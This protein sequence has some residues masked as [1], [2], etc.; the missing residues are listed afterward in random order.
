[1]TPAA[2]VDQLR[3]AAVSDLH[4][5]AAMRGTFAPRWA[6]L[7]GKADLLVLCGDLTSRGA[8]EE[9]RE[10]LA[11]LEAVEVPTVAVLG[12]HDFDQ[13]A[14]AEISS[15]LSA[16]GIIVLDGNSATLRLQSVEV[17]IAG[18]KGFCGGFR[19]ARVRAEGEAVMRDFAIEGAKE[20]SKLASAL[21][22]LRTPIRIVLTHYSP[23][24]G[25]LVG[26][27]RE[28]VPF[29]G[30]YRLE[31]AIDAAKPDAV[32]HGH[33]HRGSL[34]G[35]TQGGVA[36]YNVAFPVHRQAFRIFSIP[37][38]QS[39]TRNSWVGEHNAEI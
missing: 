34:S 32:F 3:I 10:L 7:R 25:T 17:G 30:D 20:S 9:A 18:V 16:A 12:N 35:F 11:E 4:F 38:R 29:L 24:E 5:Y 15:M 36:V 28:L 39:S 14:E 27:P 13:G 21:E 2:V 1:M 6:E 8:V 23:I 31:D 33:A 26:E 37:I 22:A 19:T